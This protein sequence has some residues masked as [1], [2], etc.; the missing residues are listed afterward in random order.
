MDLT[1]RKTVGW[2]L[3]DDMTIKNT[4]MK[5]WCS[6]REQRDLNDDFIFHS[7]SGVQYASNK[8]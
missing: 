2:A 5:A 4:V 8:K 6:A 3:S 1:D 7:D